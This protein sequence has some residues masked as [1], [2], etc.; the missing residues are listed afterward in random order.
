MERQGGVQARYD[1]VR[2]EIRS[3][4][5]GRVV[6][7]KTFTSSCS[8]DQLQSKSEEGRFVQII[9]SGAQMLDLDPNNK[10]LSRDA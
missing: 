2:D 8:N 4:K 9:S 10:G 7:A 1:Y 6:L 5:K 3:Q